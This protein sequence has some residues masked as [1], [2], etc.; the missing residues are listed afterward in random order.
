LEGLREALRQG[1]LSGEPRTVLHT[2]WRPQ[3]AA[4]FAREW[5]SMDRR[6]APTAVVFVNDLMALGFLRQ[7]H[8]LGFKIP[9]DVSITGMDDIY[10]SSLTYPA[11][12]TIKQSM[13]AMGA[14]C[15]RSLVEQLRKPDQ[16]KWPPI[17]FPVE[18]VV[19]ESTSIPK[20]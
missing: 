4:E 19:R 13:G 16:K 20:S 10:Y 11:L 12:T 9:R 15:I 17:I 14:A 3:E 18:L 1:G 6:K 7:V 5:A 8:Q 2:G